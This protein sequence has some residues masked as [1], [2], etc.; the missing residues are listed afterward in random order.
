[1]GGFAPGAAS[2]GLHRQTYRCNIQPVA[3]QRISVDFGRKTC[4]IKRF[5]SQS[6]HNVMKLLSVGFLLMFSAFAGMAQ[7]LTST[8]TFTASGYIGTPATATTP[9]QGQTFTNASITI[10]A[11]GNTA[12]RIYRSGNYCMQ[13]DSATVTISGV[14]T[15][16]LGSSYLYSQAVVDPIKGIIG[17]TI[18]FA[19]GFLGNGS[20]I[21]AMP[22]ATASASVQQSSIWDMTSS[23]GPLQANID[24]VSGALPTSAGTLQFLQVMFGL[25]GR[26]Q[27]I[28]TGTPPPPTANVYHLRQNHHSAG[29]SESAQCY[30]WGGGECRGA[31]RVREIGKLERDRAPLAAENVIE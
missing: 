10:T 25:S 14:A 23:L 31:R 9:F 12:N 27:A 4:F 17:N 2:A 30:G 29:N 19:D 13:N 16:Q 22:D 26:F 8:L 6:K 18:G 5:R 7:I 11:V 20:C 21:S 3:F 28:F 15:Y 1:M 24:P